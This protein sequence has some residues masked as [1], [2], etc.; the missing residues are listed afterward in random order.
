[1]IAVAAHICGGSFIHIYAKEN[2]HMSEPKK[3]DA[4]ELKKYAHE[5]K[6]GDKI[7][8]SGTVYTSRDAAHAEIRVLKHE[9]QK[10]G[11]QPDA[12]GK[13]YRLMRTYHVGKNG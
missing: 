10:R 4:S 2:E 13:T 1:M 3:I 12:G 5:L 8:L 6:A 9:D 11:D 7:F